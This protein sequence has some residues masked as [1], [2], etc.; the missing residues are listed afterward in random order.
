MQTRRPKTNRN[1]TADGVPVVTLFVL[2]TLLGLVLGAG[3]FDLLELAT[4]ARPALGDIIVFGADRPLARDVAGQ[5]AAQHV[6]DQEFGQAGCMLDV[7]IMRRSGGSLIV[8]ERAPGP[9]ARVRVHWSGLRTSADAD[10]CGAAA[11]LLLR[12]REV[13]ALA[14]GAGGYGAGLAA[15]PGAATAAPAR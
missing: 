11:D 9:T 10:N 6:G 1:R 3:S 12:P 13:N 7:G 14:L 2:L 8:E 4:N 15:R 5:V